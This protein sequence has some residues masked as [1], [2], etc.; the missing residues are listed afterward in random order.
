[1]KS[2]VTFEIRYWEWDWDTIE[3]E[4]FIS[5]YWLDLEVRLVSR[6]VGDWEWEYQS[7]YVN[8]NY[9]IPS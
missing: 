5:D 6:E 8:C 4:S 2:F 7:K 1:M 3:L 9:L